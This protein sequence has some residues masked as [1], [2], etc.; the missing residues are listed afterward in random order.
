MSLHYLNVSVENDAACGD[1]PLGLCVDVTP[2]L[3]RR[4]VEHRVFVDLRNGGRQGLSRLRSGK[5]IASL[6]I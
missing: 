1:E 3:G 4:I 5:P 6:N 2:E